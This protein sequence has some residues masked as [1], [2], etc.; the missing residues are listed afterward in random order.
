MK[1]DGKGEGE[2][3]GECK[4]EGE[5]GAGGAGEGSAGIKREGLSMLDGPLF[6]RRGVGERDKT[7]DLLVSACVGF[8]LVRK[9][10]F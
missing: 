9:T 1:G 2:G 5:G 3:V 10:L 8:D 7:E 6:Q 4:G